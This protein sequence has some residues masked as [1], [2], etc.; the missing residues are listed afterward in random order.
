MCIYCGGNT[1]AVT[2]DHMPPKVMF[3]KKDRPEGLEFP[4]CK[5]CNNGA[6][7]TDTVCSLI[8]RIYPDND[9]PSAISDFVKLLSGTHN[10]ASD[11]FQEFMSNLDNSTPC[12]E[13]FK[14]PEGT[15]TFTLGPVAKAHLEAFGARF[16]LAM[17][18]VATGN[19][20]DKNGAIFV[21]IFTNFDLLNSPPPESLFEILVPKTLEQGQKNT[22]GQFRYDCAALPD[23]SASISFATFRQ[24]YGLLAISVSPERAD[25]RATLE[26]D[27][28]AFS[29]GCFNHTEARP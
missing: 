18:F 2:I 7:I 11:F 17:H 10:N 27:A 8:G 21:R 3:D 6:G 9:D 4:S 29:P 16:G 5:S 25:L 20:L 15:E 28:K 12:E 26:M 22:Y 24:S 13:A 14:A 19:I 1:P 23:R